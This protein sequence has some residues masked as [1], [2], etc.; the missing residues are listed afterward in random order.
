MK[1]LLLVTSN[2][3]L[4]C[5]TSTALSNPDTLWTRTYGGSKY[6]CCN[7][8][9]QTSD[10]GYILVGS[11]ESFGQGLNDVYLIHID[12]KGDT[13][14][15]NTYGGKDEDWGNSIGLTKD[16]GFIVAGRTKSFNTST[17]DVYLLR[18]KPDGDTLWTKTYYKNGLSADVGLSTQQTIDG[19][20]VILGWTDY[21]NEHKDIYLIKT[22]SSGD[23]LWTKIYRHHVGSSDI[24]YSIYET[25]DSGFIIAGSTSPFNSGFTD[26]YLI[27]TNSKGDTTWTKTYGGY[28]FEQG[29]SVQQTHDG[30]YIIAGSSLSFGAGNHDVYLV[31]TDAKGD[32]LWTKT[33]GGGDIDFGYS[34]Q[35]T[36]DKG[37]VITGKTSSFGNGGEDLYLIRTN[38]M[39]SVLWT[40][41]YGGFTSEWGKSMC[42]VGDGGIIISGV[43]YSFGNGGGDVYIVRMDSNSIGIRVDNFNNPSLLNNVSISHDYLSHI[44]SVYFNLS[45][46]S[47]VKIE[48]FHANGKL[49]KTVVDDFFSHGNHVTRWNIRQN[50][51]SYLSNG[52][53]ILRFRSK[54]M[55]ISKKLTI[56]Y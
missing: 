43:S 10:S 29:L 24:G 21:L 11:T 52:T 40:K 20:F 47:R 36:V 54:E 42:L 17:S 25:T 51:D 49:V 46:S 1:F 2:L 53:Y 7:G 56:F 41:T 13:L 28:Y 45:L 30:G 37:Y 26:L 33:Y 44:V 27:K 14:W 16:G 31:K 19:G 34:V 3:L 48:V 38:E 8:I 6:D 9:K 39:G 4:Y 12:K 15:T 55:A 35:Q 32:S 23:T 5:L 18:I 22:N 50:R